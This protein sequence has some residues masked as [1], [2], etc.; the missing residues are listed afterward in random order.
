[1]AHLSTSQN[2]LVLMSNLV[3][4]P[5]TTWSLPLRPREI[6]NLFQFK[7]DQI[8]SS[9]EVHVINTQV[10]NTK[11]AVNTSSVVNVLTGT[12]VQDQHLWRTGLRSTVSVNAEAGVAFSP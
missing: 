1:M 5:S 2:F 7:R 6:S 4:T 8:V 9:S 10:V 12:T 11:T 3:E